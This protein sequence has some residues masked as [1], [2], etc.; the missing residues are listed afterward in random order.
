MQNIG[1][2]LKESTKACED[3]EDIEDPWYQI[4]TRAKSHLHT[5]IA[6]LAITE[7]DL[8][9]KSVADPNPIAETRVELVDGELF[10]DIYI[11]SA[12]YALKPEWQAA[13]IVHEMSHAE[14]AY[15]LYDKLLAGEATVSDW[16][17]KANPSGGHDASWKSITR[18]LANASGVKAD[19]ALI[20]TIDFTDDSL[21]LD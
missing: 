12:F 1:K 4:A 2:V 20:T 19:M 9:P 13:V 7:E 8:D 11:D 14:D 3:V 16:K 18:E 15:R 6:G 10:V 17:K 21:F 5:E